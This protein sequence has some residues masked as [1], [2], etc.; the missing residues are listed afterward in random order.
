M[1]Y[2]QKYNSIRQDNIQDFGLNSVMEMPVLE[3]IVVNIGFGSNRENKKYVEEA[4]NDIQ[5]ITGQKPA[6]RK[7]KKSISNFKLREGQV[8]GYSVTL[9]G[10]SMWNF[11]EKFVKIVLP[12]IKDFRGLNKKAFDQ[13]G[14]YSIGIT[15]HSVF[16]EVDANSIT[17]LKPLQITFVIKRSTKE[18]SKQLLKLL[19]LPIRD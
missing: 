14:S 9:R 5:A 6:A 3:K 12:R 7:A 4:L 13:G 19:D 2:K 1:E 8:I 18:K 15:D 17:F 10:R 11:Y 16:Q